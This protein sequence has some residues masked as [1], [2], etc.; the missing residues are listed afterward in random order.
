MSSASHTHLLGFGRLSQ[1]APGQA[2]DVVDPLF[3]VDIHVKGTVAHF[4]VPV[5]A[6]VAAVPNDNHLWPL[7]ATAYRRLELLICAA[8]SHVLYTESTVVVSHENNDAALMT[9]DDGCECMLL[10]TGVLHGERK[11]FGKHVCGRG[12]IVDGRGRREEHAGR[13]VVS[14][15]SRR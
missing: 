3:A 10:A 7:F 14:T 9:A 12:N 13:W 15:A 8:L 1:E 5:D 6:L 4:L 11:C 2:E